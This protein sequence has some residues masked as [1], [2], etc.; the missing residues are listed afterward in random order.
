MLKRLFDTGWSDE[1]ECQAC[2]KGGRHRKAQVY[3]CPEGYEVRREI[4]E[5]FRKWEQQAR[6][7]KKECKWQRGIGP[8]PLSESKWN[9]S[10]FSMKQWESEKRVLL[11]CAF[12]FAAP[13][14]ARP[15][16]SP[17]PM[18]NAKSWLLAPRDADARGVFVGSYAMRKWRFAWRWHVLRI[19]RSSVINVRKP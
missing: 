17:R 11:K 3:H 2:H 7:S 14:C 8:H 5:A 4:P 15:Q 6:T 12:F 19:M 16:R 13:L 10:H 9:R 18:V 1:S